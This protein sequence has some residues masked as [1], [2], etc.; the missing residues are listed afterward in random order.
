MKKLFVNLQNLSKK[1]N[2]ID[3]YVSHTFKKFLVDGV[4]EENCFMEGE[5]ECVTF[6][7][8]MTSPQREKFGNIIYPNE[9]DVSTVQDD[10]YILNRVPKVV[11]FNK[12]TG[13]KITTH[14]D[15]FSDDNSNFGAPVISTSTNIA[16]LYYGFVVYGKKTIINP[17]FDTIRVFE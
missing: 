1:T 7:S 6:Y 3:R 13:Q 15:I 2:L 4:Y 10:K 14:F 8:C 17:V 16:K 11:H 12:E 5:S 9:L